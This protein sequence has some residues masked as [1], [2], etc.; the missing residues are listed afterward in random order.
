[1][2]FSQYNEQLLGLKIYERLEDTEKNLWM[3]RKWRVVYL[4][5]PYS[6]KLCNFCLC[7]SCNKQLTFVIE[8]TFI[9]K[10]TKC[11][12]IQPQQTHLRSAFPWRPYTH[13]LSTEHICR[14]SPTL[15]CRKAFC[16]WSVKLFELISTGTKAARASTCST[17]ERV[18]LREL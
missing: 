12:W 4:K 9:T 16:R 8:D 6:T 11:S 17:F 2:D 10:P 1:M 5:C 3:H 18:V 7:D 15:G 14:R 13:H